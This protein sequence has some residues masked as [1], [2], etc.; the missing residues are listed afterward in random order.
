MIKPFGRNILV[1]PI[2]EKQT[3]VSETPSLAQYGIVIEIGKDVIN[4]K[5]GDKIG[6]LLWGVNHLEIEGKKYYFVPE[7]DEFILGT[8]DE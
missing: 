7:Q 1:E 8:I 5:K 6:F 3:L 2:Q 4:I